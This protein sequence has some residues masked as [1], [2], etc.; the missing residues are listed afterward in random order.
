MSDTMDKYFFRVCAEDFKKIPGN[1]IPFWLS[2]KITNKFVDTKLLGDLSSLKQGMSTTDADRFVRNWQEVNRNKTAFDCDSAIVGNNQG[3]Y[4]FPFNKG[5]KYRKWF[6][7]NE[8]V[9]RYENNGELL[10]EMVRNKYPKISDPEFVIKNRKRYFIESVTYTAIS[11]SNFG[12]RLMP[13][14]FIFSIAGPVIQSEVLDNYVILSLLLSPV[15]IKIVSA[16]SPTL[17]FQ[18]VDLEKIP[19]DKSLFQEGSNSLKLKNITTDLIEISIYDWDNYEISWNFT[20][21][22]FFNS[23]YRQNTINATYQKLRSNWFLETSKMKTLEEE[24]NKIIISAYELEE[25]LS[26]EVPLRAITL[27]CNPYYRYDSDK[28]E[29]ELE[30]LLL[31]DTMKEL[32]SYGVGCM[33][34]RY[35]LDKPG[36]ILA[37]HGDGMNEYL[38]EIPNPS[39]PIDDD[40]II[41]VLEDD[42]FTDDIASRFVEF[43]KVAFGEEHHTENIRFIE[44]AIGKSIRKYFVKG[45]YDDHIKRY[46]K[47]PIYW[48]VSSPKKSFNALIYMH[49][50]QDDIFARVQNNYLREYITKLEASM[51]TATTIVNDESNSVADRRKATKDIETITK[52]IDELIKFD[53]DKLT[54]FAQSRTPI[55]LDDGVKL[56]Y[57]KFEEIL[58]PIPGL[59]SEE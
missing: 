36:L 52:K 40:N 42:Y 21:F 59:K 6:G 43:I 27:T 54:P 22:P 4:W 45:F 56:N 50:Y 55:D 48:M 41:P 16:L 33:F 10:L 1:P 13:K 25:E 35:S 39:F 11:S 31:A 3:A 28:S 46:K 29:E 44:D 57:S 15:A 32:I 34:G 51:H 23:N 53:R 20:I 47:R 14:G 8:Q 12:V 49:R 19:I 7:N 24:I 17:N 38:K 26:H 30:S 5:G 37:N 18:A 9:V 2:K 58:Y